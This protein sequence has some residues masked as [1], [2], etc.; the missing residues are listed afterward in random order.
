LSV[1]AGG[2]GVSEKGREERGGEVEKR[3]RKGREEREKG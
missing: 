1:G 3:Q 2:G